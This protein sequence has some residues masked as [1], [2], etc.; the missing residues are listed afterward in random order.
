MRD[1]S[2]PHETPPRYPPLTPRRL[3]VDAV[4]I[5]AFLA[6]LYAIEHPIAAATSLLLVGAV[7][8]AIRWE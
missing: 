4:V 2:N 1:P 8:A 6:A 7:T 3:L 5:A